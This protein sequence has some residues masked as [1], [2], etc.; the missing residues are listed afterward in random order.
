M[1]KKAGA[2]PV[3]LPR[4][5]CVGARSGLVLFL[6]I[7]YNYVS[8]EWHGR[9]PLFSWLPESSILQKKSPSRPPVVGTRRKGIG[10]N[11]IRGELNIN[12]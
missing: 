11:K 12:N 1:I 7:F 2:P 8:L 10:S 3:I 6:P 5:A 4:V 9:L